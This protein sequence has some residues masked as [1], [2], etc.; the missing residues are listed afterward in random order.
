VNTEFR[1]DFW[2]NKILQWEAAKYGRKLPL[3]DLNQNVKNRRSLAHKLLATQVA[4]KNVLEIGCGSGWMAEK[5]LQA[6]A[7]SYTGLDISPVAIQR[8]KQ[9][10]QE[11]N[12]HFQAIAHLSE[13]RNLAVAPE[14]CFSLGLT[15]WLNPEELDLLAEYSRDKFYLHSYSSARFSPLRFL[16]QSYVYLFYGHRAPLY[17]PR[18]Y[19]DF[20]FQEK[21]PD[22]GPTLS[23]GLGIGRIVTNFQKKT[24]GDSP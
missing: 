12:C 21:F 4:E 19:S 2:N 3:I 5:V 16:H 24:V 18:Y 7:Q 11:K 20:F 15:D 17:Q 9:L 10:Y 6:G 23:A 22:A 1:T 13:L 14:I 8:A